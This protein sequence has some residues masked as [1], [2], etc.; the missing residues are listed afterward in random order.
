[1]RPRWGGWVDDMSGVDRYYLEIFKLEPNI[2]HELV[3][4]E[5]LNPIY[6]ITI[7]NES[8][9]VSFLPNKTGMYS[10]LLQVSDQA[11][12]SRIA[13]QLFLYDNVS[14]IE[15]T[16]P[17]LIERMPTLTEV[18][19]MHRGDGGFHVLSAIPETGF[20]WQTT[21]S[22]SR[23]NIVFNWENHFVNTL[24]DEGMLLN[25]VLPYPTQFQDLQDDGVLRSSK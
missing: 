13:R 24:I 4:M 5:P 23:A 2:H 8:E 20:M 12:N 17:G 15:F 7:Y 16:K 22:K 21:S 3:E 11:N 18:T 19:E 1:M 14:D 6:N 25:K 9:P 10:V